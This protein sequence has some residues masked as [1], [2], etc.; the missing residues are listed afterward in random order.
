M[1][2]CLLTLVLLLIT[3]TGV[4]PCCCS[5]AR[6][7]REIS[8][9]INAKSVATTAKPSC[10]QTRNLPQRESEQDQTPV[11]KPCQCAKTSCQSLPPDPL[12]ITLETS[13]LAWDVIVYDFR[14]TLEEFVVDSLQSEA[15][16]SRTGP[17]SLT[18]RQL[19]IAH[20]SWR[21]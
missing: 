6:I 17:P 5:L 13:R 2:R 15:D 11:P 16:V 10:C 4:T 12:A 14:P 1:L 20:C 8:S 9:L 18:G 21:C 3:L 19:R 7:S